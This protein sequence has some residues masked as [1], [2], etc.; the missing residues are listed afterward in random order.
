[1][2]PRKVKIEDLRSFV[3]VSDPQVSPDGGNAAFVHTAVDLD[4]DDYVKHVW[5]LETATGRHRQFTAG[6]GKD[7]SPRWS[8]DGSRLLFL[9]SGREPEKKNQLYVI[10]AEGGE[11]RLAADMETGVM[12]PRW[13]PNGREILFTSRVWEPE[14]PETDVVV[15]KRIRY[16]LNGVGMFAGKRVHLHKVKPGGKPKQLT[17]GEI[18]VDAADW[19]P[20]GKQIA[21]VS[22]VEED[23][24]TTHVRH[25]Y[26]MPS[27]GGEMKR[28]TEAGHSVSDLS[29][30]PDGAEIAYTGNDFHARGAT[31]DDIWVMPSKGGSPR[32]VTAGFDRSIGR[33]IGSDLRFPSPNPGPVWSRDGESIYFLTGEVPTANVYRVSKATGDVARITSG[34]SVDGFSLSRDESVL[35]YNAMNAT[36]PCEIWVS[37]A[38]GERKVTGFNDRLLKRLCVVEPEHHTWLNE[39]GDEIDGWVMKPVGYTDGERYPAILEIHGGPLGIY[40]DGIYQ[41]FQIL[42]SA[43][44]CVIYTNPRGSGGYGEEYGATLNGRHGTVD[45]RDIMDFTVDAVERFGFIDGDRL[46]VT[47]GSY[48]GYLTN[49]IVTQ[50]DMFKAAVACRSTCNRH[51]HHG[52]SDLGYKHGESGNMGYPWRDEDK[53]LAQ[54]P[55]RYAENVETPTLLIHSENDQRCTIQQA[56]EFFVA[57]KELGVDTEL[58]RFPEESHELSRSGKPKHREERLRH[59]LRWFEKYLK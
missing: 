47:G 11:A 3:F 36:H 12:N 20:D 19:S 28:I 13:A 34:R 15:V 44:Y 52:Y 32:N 37:D 55:I 16:K 8:P 17:E 30:S 10:D 27:K 21:L 2:T 35:V 49:W 45:Y 43:G 50:T 23:A 9:S 5:M 46:G 22:N 56:E 40:G 41:E 29:W 26:L 1:M 24:D 42:T 53:L 14:K 31:N 59:I 57:L 6:P 25:I 18:D 39:L 48:G 58:V 33:G 38:E 4:E 51:S 54:S 7:S